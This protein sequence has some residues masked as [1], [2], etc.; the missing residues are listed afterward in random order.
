MWV[1][2][3]IKYIQS[4]KKP[5]FINH[6]TGPEIYKIKIFIKEQDNHWIYNT[7]PSE[8]CS[9]ACNHVLLMIK[10]QTKWTQS[11]A[12]AAVPSFLHVCYFF[13]W[14]SFIAAL[15][16][17]TD[18]PFKTA[19]WYYPEDENVL[20]ITILRFETETEEEN[21]DTMN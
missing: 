5:H 15:S 20:W 14:W 11:H 13:Y 7:N 19:T 4:W 9:L 2:S 3:T 12:L 6:F 18:V 17:Y 10:S 16:M 8:M 1:I 21:I